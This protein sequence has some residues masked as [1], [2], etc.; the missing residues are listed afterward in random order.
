VVYRAIAGVFGEGTRDMCGYDLNTLFANMKL[1][2]NNFKILHKYHFH[3]LAVIELCSS[4]NFKVIF[5]FTKHFLIFYYI[6]D[7]TGY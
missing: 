6:I 3:S 5:S 1:P 7:N 4:M 2:K